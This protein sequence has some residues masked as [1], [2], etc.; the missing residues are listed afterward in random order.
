[1]KIMS[2]ILMAMINQPASIGAFGAIAKWNDMKKFG[3]FLFG[4]ARVAKKNYIRRMWIYAVPQLKKQAMLMMNSNLKK[5]GSTPIIEKIPIYRM[6]NMI[7]TDS[8]L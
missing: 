6:M 5:N 2:Y 1:M 7:M 8:N 4:D 3:I